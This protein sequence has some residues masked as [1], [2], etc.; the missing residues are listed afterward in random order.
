MVLLA[1]TAVALGFLVVRARNADAPGGAAAQGTTAPTGRGPGAGST[2][3]TAAP[4]SVAPAGAPSSATPQQQQLLACI[5]WNESRNEYGAVSPDGTAFG[6]YQ[7]TQQTWNET[8]EHA[9]YTNLVGVQPNYATPAQ[10]DEVALALLEW[11][12]TSPWNGD[13]CVSG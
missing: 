7:I 3:G 6:A 8:A 4:T 2:R 9:G 12:G 10:Q 5:S 11:Q 1:I 13:P